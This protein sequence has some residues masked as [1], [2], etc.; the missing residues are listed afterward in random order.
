MLQRGGKLQSAESFAKLCD[1]AWKARRNSKQKQAQL[2]RCVRWEEVIQKLEMEDAF[3]GKSRRER[4]DLARVAVVTIATAVVRDIL[5]MVPAVREEVKQSLGVYEAQKQREA[6]DPTYVPEVRGKYLP[7]YILDFCHK[8]T[9][10]VGRS[11]MCRCPPKALPGGG[12]CLWEH[13]NMHGFV[14]HATT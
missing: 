3:K 4:R 14:F 7:G 13:N 9:T 6:E 10:S 8:I 2:L 1:K 5:E 11:Y 12:A